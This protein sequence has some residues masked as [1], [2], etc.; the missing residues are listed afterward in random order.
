[1]KWEALTQQ[2]TDLSATIVTI[3]M[4][5][6]GRGFHTEVV[7]GNGEVRE[8]YGNTARNALKE[9]ISNF[10]PGGDRVFAI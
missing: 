9:A 1:M 7:F 6:V 3:T 4:E 8:A 10:N 5:S 2:K